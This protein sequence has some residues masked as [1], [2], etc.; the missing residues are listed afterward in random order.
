MRR[1]NIAFIIHIF[2]LLH[3]AVALTCRLAGIEDELLLTILTMAMV[4]LICLRKKFSIEFS[5]ASVIVANLIGYLLG[6]IGAEILEKFISSPYAVH[7]LS[8]AITTELLG[9]G[10]M[11]FSRMFSYDRKK[12]EGTSTESYLKWTITVIAGIFVF[13]LGIIL[14]FSNQPFAKMTLQEN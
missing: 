3:A 9:W 14:L 2:A 4:L 8:T 5:A 10:T 11:L 13:R 6:N 7:A 1:H 12:S